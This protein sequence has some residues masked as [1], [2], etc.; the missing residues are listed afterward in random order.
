VLT[1]DV[2]DAAA[3]GC[4]LPPEGVKVDSDFGRKKMDAYVET[5]IEA[6]TVRTSDLVATKPK[7]Q[8]EDDEGDSAGGGEF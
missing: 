6:L 5:L 8:Y 1:A 4:S 3:Y 7:N 2:I